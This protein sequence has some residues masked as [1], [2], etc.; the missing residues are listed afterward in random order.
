[1]SFLDRLEAGNSGRVPEPVTQTPKSTNVWLDDDDDDGDD[2]PQDTSLST[3]P[4]PSQLH[5]DCEEED[6]ES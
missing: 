2:E 5:T 4:N 6:G 3:I 1:M